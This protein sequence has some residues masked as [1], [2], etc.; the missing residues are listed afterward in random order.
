MPQP[1]LKDVLPVDASAPDTSNDESDLS[2]LDSE[3]A[4]SA[5]VGSGQEL[6]DV[7]NSQD[8]YEVERILLSRHDSISGDYR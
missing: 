7:N 1:A 8:E 3:A 2:D 6:D 5:C 4:E